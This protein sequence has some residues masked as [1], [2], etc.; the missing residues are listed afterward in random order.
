MHDD[1]PSDPDELQV[2]QGHLIRLLARIR[3]QADAPAPLYLPVDQAWLQIIE[4]HTVEQLRRAGEQAYE[5]DTAIN[6]GFP[7]LLQGG[8]C[9]TCLPR[10]ASHH[11]AS[12]TGG[13]AGSTTARNSPRRKPPSTRPGRRWSCAGYAAP[14]HRWGRY[15]PVHRP[16][17]RRGPQVLLKNLPDRRV[18]TP[19]VRGTLEQLVAKGR[20]SRSRQGRTVYYTAD[21]SIASLVMV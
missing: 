14:T 18:E 8:G 12:C 15:R 10:S 21:V 17:R 2:I 20:I 16:T 5:V 7:D 6:P 9:S 1:L 13:S 4:A 11:A 3:E 19:V